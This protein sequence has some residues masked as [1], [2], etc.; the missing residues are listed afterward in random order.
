MN[1]LSCFSENCLCLSLQETL[2][3]SFFPLQS[4][5][6]K[7]SNHLFIQ[8]SSNTFCYQGSCKMNHYTLPCQFGSNSD[9]NT[10]MSGLDTSWILSYLLQGSSRQFFLYYSPLT[11]WKMR[12]STEPVQQT[13]TA[14]ETS[15][16]GI[17]KLHLAC[18]AGVVLA[19][20][21]QIANSAKM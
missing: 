5:K 2:D 19:T 16:V 15:Q 8:A 14:Y 4:I 11:S 21:T 12:I 3:S 17:Q 9:F 6:F 7:I 10:F 1:L 20:T 13:I 18:R